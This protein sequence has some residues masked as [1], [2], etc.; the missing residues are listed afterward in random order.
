MISET[1]YRIS[2]AAKLT[3]QSEIKSKDY[4]TS[5]RIQFY[6]TTA[7]ELQFQN[8]CHSELLELQH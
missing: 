1:N 4:H 6:Y 7:H 2:R 3:N 8:H 5:D